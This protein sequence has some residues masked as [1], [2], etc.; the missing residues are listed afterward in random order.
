[1][2]SRKILNKQNIKFYFP[3]KIRWNPFSYLDKKAKKIP[4]NII[5]ASVFLI[6]SLFLLKSEDYRINQRVLGTQTQLVTDQKSIYD[7][8][9]ILTERPDYRDGW[10]QLAA[11]YYKLGNKGKAKDAILQAKSLDP[12]NQTILSFEKLIGD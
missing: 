10:V 8:E 2:A 7:W 5:L 9:Q 4:K 12:T 6:I 1:M 11:I 3:T